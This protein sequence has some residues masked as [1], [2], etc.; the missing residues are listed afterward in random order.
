MPRVCKPSVAPI[1][2]RGREG[3]SQAIIQRHCNGLATPQAA[4]AFYSITPEAPANVRSFSC[5][6]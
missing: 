1:I 5:A 3:N 4:R 6:A 2:N